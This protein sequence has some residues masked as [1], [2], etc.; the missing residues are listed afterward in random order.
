MSIAALQITQ[1]SGTNIVVDSTATGNVQVIKLADSTLGSTSMVPASASTGLLVSVS[2]VSGNVTVVNPGGGAKL[3]VDGSGVTQPVSGTV[4]V[5]AANTAPVAVRLSSGAAWVD[6]IPVSIA[7]T[8]TV[9]GAVTISGT[10]AVSQSGTWNIGTVATITN[11]VTVTGT[12][13]LSGTSPVSGT[14]T[15]NQGTAAATANAWPTKITDGT[16]VITL[17][18]VAGTYTVPVKVL[19]TIGG[20]VSLQDKTAFT[21][22]TT[23]VDV[24]GGVYND[25][26]AGSPSA[27][28]ASTVRITAFRAFHTN[29]RDNSGNEVGVNTKPLEVHPAPSGATGGATRTPWKSHVAFTASLTGQVIRTPTAGKI[30]FIEGFTVQFTGSGALTIY[31]QTDSASTRINKGTGAATTLI[32]VCPATPIPTSAVNNVIYFTTGVG[33][34]GDI[35]MWGYEA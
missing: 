34:V 32:T 26:F 25:A 19:S 18:N 22:G 33:A 8:V 2:A 29:L 15:S 9:S 20:G 4:T 7:G 14:V 21:E 16:N 24:C 1:G 12:V 28:Q 17:A 31:D 30:S 23:Y 6:T 35:T 10:P 11:P 3:A 13:A 27:G 5:T